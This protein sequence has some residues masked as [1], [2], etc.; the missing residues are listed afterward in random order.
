MQK[1]HFLNTLVTKNMVWNRFYKSEILSLF[2]STRILQGFLQSEYL[3]SYNKT[4]A[5]LQTPF[6]CTGSL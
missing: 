4:Y 2:V 6:E 3:F 5:E 1:W